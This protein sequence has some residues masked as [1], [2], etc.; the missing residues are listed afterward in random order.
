MWWLLKKPCEK[1]R[2]RLS[3]E[4]VQSAALAFQGVHHVHGGDCLS[5]GV[6]SV[7]NSITDHVLQEHLE[8]TT[9]LLVDQAGDTLHTTTPSQPTD[10][11][12]GDPLNVITKDL[13]VALSTS[14]SQTLAS[15]STS[16]HAD[17]LSNV[18]EIFCRNSITYQLLVTFYVKIWRFFTGPDRKTQSTHA[19]Y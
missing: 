10:S 11:W 13:S 19:H 8:N 12:F 2:T 15:F 16:R 17:S 9:G 1:G 6:L 3:A 18:E 5:F 14:F 7:G 4:T